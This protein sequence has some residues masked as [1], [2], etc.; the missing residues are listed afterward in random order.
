MLNNKV[1]RYE[2]C[3]YSTGS[4]EYGYHAEVQLELVEFNIVKE[5]PKGIWIQ[6]GTFVEPRKEGRKFINLHSR[7]K[8]ATFTKKEAIESYI[9]RK[10]RQIIILNARLA[11]AQQALIMGNQTKHELESHS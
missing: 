11:T 5:T 2:D 7:K 9:K 1:Y 6:F 3:L 4:E 8:F 10:Q